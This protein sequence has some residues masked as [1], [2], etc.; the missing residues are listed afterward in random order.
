MDTLYIATVLAE[1]VPIRNGPGLNHATIQDS[2]YHKGNTF[3]IS[4]TETDGSK[5]WGYDGGGWVC[6]I[7]GK[8]RYVDYKPYEK[9]KRMRKAASRMGAGTSGVA[10]GVA[11]LGQ[12]LD[13]S[14]GGDAGAS[15]NIVNAIKNM[16]QAAGAAGV[17]A[18]ENV[19]LTPEDQFKVD[20]ANVNGIFGELMSS[21]TN[22]GQLFKKNMRLFGLPYQF[23]KEIDFRVDQVSTEIGRK[24]IEN[25]MNVAPVVTFIPGKPKYLPGAKN[26]QGISHALIQAATGS[27]E[28]LKQALQ[29]SD[30]EIR[31]YDFQQTY[32]EYMK[33][34]NILC[35]TAATF[36]ELTETIDGTPLQSY[37][38]RNY[39]WTGQNYQY[40][41]GKMLNAAWVGGTN[42]VNGFV[43]KVKE[44]G[45]PAK[46]A[47]DKVFGKTNSDGNKFKYTT[48]E[49]TEAEDEFADSILESSNF[50]QFYCD[51][52]MGTSESASNSTS[53]SKIKGMFDSASDA[54]KELSFV[55]N[56]G[57]MNTQEMQDWAG[58]SFNAL[59]DK[60]S[61]GGG[62]TEFLKRIIDTSGNIIKGENVIMPEIYNNSSYDKQYNITVH[63][64]APYG[65]R[66][67]YYLDVLVPL[68]HLMALA[69]PKQT[70]ANTYGAPF[71]I[72]AYCEGTFTCNL[73]IVS[74]ISIN[75]N[76]SPESWTNDGFPSEMDVTLQLTDL[77]SDLTMS[78]QSSPAMFLSN[79]SLIDYLATTCG[80]SLIQPQINMRLKYTIQ[81]IKNSF[82][83]IGTNVLS[84]A[85][86]MIEDLIS[87][88]FSID[89]R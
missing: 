13:S 58:S 20:Q 38:W 5:I 77:Y 40:V 56:S 39:R 51:P 29:D 32:T 86:N 66:F 82:G 33:Y 84:E 47:F 18:A 78:P 24:F 25:I 36:L 45:T 63:L 8:K 12:P 73:G 65:N 17:A 81:A 55:T 7:N 80:L 26:K 64:K 41:A 22:N 6:L 46:A 68:F 3:Y 69:L 42:V 49:S 50:I 43:E 28:E 88:W 27:F 62:M 37:D 57:G 48:S 35:R 89:G 21:S 31:Y 52:D 79:S 2:V 16:A 9:P 72:K 61:S 60:M 83:D 19:Q 71:L 10:G 30:Q 14:S 76:V 85:N 44:F 54:L 4:K 75:K 70:S 74:S 23:R 59:A 1:T 11:G 15:G 34:V 87:P 67:A 53:E